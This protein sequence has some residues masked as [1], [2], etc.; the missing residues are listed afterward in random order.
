MMINFAYLC[1]NSIGPTKEKKLFEFNQDISYSAIINLNGTLYT[2]QQLVDGIPLYVQTTQ[3][4]V[5]T[6]KRTE[7]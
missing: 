5:V 6:I 1:N 7:R 4:H 2:Y 3:P